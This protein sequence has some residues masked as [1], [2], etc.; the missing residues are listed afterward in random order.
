MPFHN[1]MT[2]EMAHFKFNLHCQHFLYH[3]LKSNNQQNNKSNPNL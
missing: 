3:S 1:V 2:T